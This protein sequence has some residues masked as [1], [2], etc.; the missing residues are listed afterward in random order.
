MFHFA[1][2]N[3]LVARGIANAP[4]IL[5]VGGVPTGEVSRFE[6]S[7]VPWNVRQQT[8]RSN[9]KAI[10]LAPEARTEDLVPERRGYRRRPPPNFS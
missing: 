3:S 1:E 5:D 9:L 7:Y 10:L 8:R 2:P 6:R 4:L